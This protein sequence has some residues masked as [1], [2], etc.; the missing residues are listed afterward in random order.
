MAGS[1]D[2]GESQDKQNHHRQA[3]MWHRLRRRIAGW[4]LEGREADAGELATQLDEP[5]GWVAYNLRVLA[6]CRVLK[7]VPKCNPTPPRY[8]WGPEAQ[9]AREML[10]DDDQKDA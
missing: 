1:K 5:L 6:K 10:A 7:A 8:R 4:M 3:V 9:W 2:G